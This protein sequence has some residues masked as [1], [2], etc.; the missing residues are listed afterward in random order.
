M[1]RL[2]TDSLVKRGQRANERATRRTV[3]EVARPFNSS[4]VH[5]VHER[6][7]WVKEG[8]ARTKGVRMVEGTD[9]TERRQRR[10]SLGKMTDGSTAPPLPLPR[11]SSSFSSLIK[12]TATRSVRALTKTE[13][14]QPQR[15]RA[16]RAWNDGSIHARFKGQ[17]VTNLCICA[18]THGVGSL[19]LLILGA[20]A[21]SAARRLALLITYWTTTEK[22]FDK[23]RE[24]QGTVHVL[25]CPKCCKIRHFLLKEYDP[26][27]YSSETMGHVR[28]FS[29]S[30]RRS[31]VTKRLCTPS[32][33]DR[34]MPIVLNW[35][36]SR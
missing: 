21:P 29:A 35:L 31:P 24:I 18:P 22:Q 3:G 1:S 15:S 2:A 11:P 23:D 4:G 13:L 32:R 17:C 12:Y 16:T 9:D 19:G 28:T 6:S 36:K 30:S 26:L 34:R 25:S 7:R 5:R 33:T 14:M 20:P 10:L 8:N 27:S